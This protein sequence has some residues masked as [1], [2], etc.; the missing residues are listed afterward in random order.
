MGEVKIGTCFFEGGWIDPAPCGEVVIGDYVVLGYGSRIIRHGPIR[1]FEHDRISIGDFC[2]I[3]DGARILLGADI[4][5]GCVVG[6]LAVVAGAIPPYSIVAGNPARVIR[7]RD[8]YEMMRTFVLKYRD[9]DPVALGMKEP[10]WTLLAWR[11]IEFLLRNPTYDDCE[12]QFDEGLDVLAVV[13]SY[14][15]VMRG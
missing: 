3:G 11:D 1:P 15:A 8:A 5:K 4:G 2:Y 6:A 13:E 12:I 14:R 9:P 7:K 10:D